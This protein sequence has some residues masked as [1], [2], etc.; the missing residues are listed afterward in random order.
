MQKQEKETTS[1]TILKNQILFQ[2]NVLCEKV[3]SKRLLQMG[4]SMNNKYKS[5]N[6][7]EIRENLINITNFFS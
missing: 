7:D 6:V 2:K 4:E 3:P 1:K 5:F